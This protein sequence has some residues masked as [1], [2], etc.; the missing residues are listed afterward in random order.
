MVN[1]RKFP[2]IWLLKCLSCHFYP[3][4]FPQKYVTMHSSILHPP[5][6]N[7]MQ[8]NP[9]SEAN[10]SWTVQEISCNLWNPM[11]HSSVYKDPTL[12]SVQRQIY[13]VH[14]LLPYFLK[15]QFNIILPSTP[16]SSKRPPLK[17]FPYQIPVC[18]SL[19]ALTFHMAHPSHT[20]WFDYRSSARSVNCSRYTKTLH[21]R[22][23][24][25]CSNYL[26]KVFWFH[27]MLPE[28]PLKKFVFFLNASNV[29]QK[30]KKFNS[31]THNYSITVNTLSHSNF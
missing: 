26:F 3:D 11:V 18:I 27:R 16:I 30:T 14:E 8:H 23:E 4:V 1:T 24:F 19:L 21:H 10:T 15:T 22:S 28:F 7:S 25:D 29:W 13:P 2:L 17:V 5:T 31:Y 12:F 9:P 6:T 20:P